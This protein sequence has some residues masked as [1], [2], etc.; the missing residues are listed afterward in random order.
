MTT[1]QSGDPDQIRR[2]IERTQNH[3]S[4][5]VDVLTEKV[6]P[7]RI[8]ERRVNRVRDTA[9]RW[10]DNVMGSG[11]TS[12]S[13]GVQQA[14]SSVSDT[15]A[16]ARDNVSGAV[17]D[18]AGAVQAAPDTVRRQARGNPVAAG[19]IA[20]GV[21]WLVSSLV[22]A[23][24]REQQV[25]EQAKDRASELSGPLGQAATEVKDNLAGPAQQ[26]VESVRDT[27]TEA[28]RTVADE[29]RSAAQDVQGQAKDSAGSV[30]QAQ[31]SG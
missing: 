21:G 22:P 2:D 6:S 3:L 10:K 7:G 12:G 28:G 27:A 23:S 14:A 11:P 26:A 19:L 30:R 9:G 13:G 4:R 16:A 29:G 5:D 18:A 25:A 31:Q 17:S 24:R 20:F 8:V 15:A 1:P